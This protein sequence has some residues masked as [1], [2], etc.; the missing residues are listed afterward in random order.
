MFVYTFLFSYWNVIFNPKTI[1]KI[2]KFLKFHLLI[3]C[4]FMLL[5]YVHK[6]IYI[7]TQNTY[8]FNCIHRNHFREARC[9]FTY[10]QETGD[11]KVV[12]RMLNALLPN[13]NPFFYY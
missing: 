8:F 10:F 4:K 11:F 9:I 3:K 6:H 7:R 5:V 13:G 12:P 2:K 1:E